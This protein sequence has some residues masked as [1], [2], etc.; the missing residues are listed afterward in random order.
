MNYEPYTQREL[1]EDK[2][3]LK[4]RR[5]ELEAEI[6]DRRAEYNRLIEEATSADE[7]KRSTN[8]L[9]AK[10]AKKKYEIA[11]T[12]YRHVKRKLA[13]VLAIETVCELTST[14]DE[15]F[16]N[17]PDDGIDADAVE[18]LL[19]EVVRTHAVDADA[20]TAALEALDI[21]GLDPS[22]LDVQS[23]DDSALEDDLD[24]ELVEIQDAIAENVSDLFDGED[25]NED[26]A[27]TVSELFD[28]EDSN[29]DITEP[30][31]DVF[32]EEDLNDDTD[33]EL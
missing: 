4:R 18:Q 24:S 1:K 7:A 31:A 2:M 30:V 22:E 19:N 28:E 5:E 10:F 15:M 21:D 20:L 11:T 3:R 29:E 12:R 6:E 27:E 26:I 13:M 9:R 16:E 14:T 23:N 33:F 17:P 32:D 25:S 8:A